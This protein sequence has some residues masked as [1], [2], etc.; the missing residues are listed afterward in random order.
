MNVPISAAWGSLG[1]AN[2]TVIDARP[3]RR[4]EFAFEPAMSIQP[5][6][7]VL[8]DGT[9]A[10]LS[11]SQSCSLVMV[12]GRSAARG[13]R[14]CCALADDY[15]AAKA[16]GIETLAVPAGAARRVP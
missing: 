11:P 3:D 9:I 7:V 4:R 14:K 6:A 8:T 5:Y 15:H 16:G 10:D 12:D 1:L 13:S 2:G